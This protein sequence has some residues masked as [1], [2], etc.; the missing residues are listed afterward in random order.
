MR[1]ARRQLGAL[2]LALAAPPL[3]QAQA[4]GRIFALVAGIDAY[5]FVT[6]LRGCVNDARLIE[7]ALRPIAQR[8]TLLLDEQC[9]RAAFLGAWDALLREAVPG[10]SFVL[11]FSGHGMQFPE[12][13]RG[14]E[15]DGL[16]EAL[17]MHGFD[18]RRLP[19]SRELVLDDEIGARFAASGQRGI[20][21]VFVSDCCHAGTL[22]RSLDTRAEGA[23]TRTIGF[24]MLEADMLAL[25]TAPVQV[26][27]QQNLLFLAGAQDHELVKEV[28]IGGRFHGGLS[29]AFAHAVARAAS[30]GAFPPSEAF[31]REVMA[32][33]RA[34]NEGQHRPVGENRLA[35]HEPALPL[36]RA[37]A[38]NLPGAMAEGAPLRLHVLPGGGPL[39]EAARR[40]PGVQLTT[41]RAGAEALLDPGRAELVSGEGDLLA[42]Q[43]TPEALEGALDKFAA[44]RWLLARGLPAMEAGLVPRGAMLAPGGANSRD[45]RHPAGSEWD[46]VLRPPQAAAM[47]VV[48]LAAEGTMRV[49]SPA[50]AALE[51]SSTEFRFGV[52]VTPPPGA[53]H[54]LGVAADRPLG[55]LA[56][57]MAG[58][59]RQRAP[60]AAARALAQT[61]GLVALAQF[62]FHAA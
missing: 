35:P 8:L 56:Q 9:S 47:V 26:A 53:A 4:T 18:R 17:V 25:P 60:W 52:R 55:D 51:L 19:N 54:V 33:A 43:L 6:P 37:V 40:L 61:P 7:A 39:P 3:A 10:D 45:A 38:V 42:T 23:S 13:V 58:L 36:A 15:A 50:R 57:R 41:T 5:P 2:G 22:T 31:L 12:R 44:L 34:R 21:S 49:L 20:R 48:A 62:G 16:D 59:D 11:T 24:Q 32:G 28:R 46:L 30:A 29:H 1:L 14:S 27:G